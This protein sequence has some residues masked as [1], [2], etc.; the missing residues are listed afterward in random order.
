V[1][2]DAH[3]QIGLIRS[4]LTAQ[5]IRQDDRMQEVK[6][7]LRDVLKEQLAET[8]HP[9]VSLLVQEKV[10]ERV[11]EKVHQQVRHTSMFS[12]QTP[13]PVLE[14]LANGSDSE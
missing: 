7:L 4:Q 5:Y 9:R 11:K 3:F 8:L 10:E 6:A 13:K 12:Q 14:I 2:C 1:I